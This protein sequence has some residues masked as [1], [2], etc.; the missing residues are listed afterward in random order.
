MTSAEQIGSGSWRHAAFRPLAIPVYRRFWLAGMLSNLG[1]MM[2]SVGAAWLMTSISGKP[3]MVALVQTMT[4]LP[5]MLFSIVAGA[6][7]DIVDRRWLI[8]ASQLGMTVVALVLAGLTLSGCVTP[9][10]LLAATFLIAAGNAI[11]APAWQ[12]SVVEQVSLP[13]LDSAT[14][15]NSVGLNVARAFGPALGGAAVS[16]IGCGP[17]FALNALSNVGLIAASLSWRRER[18]V[19]PLP[20]E[21][22][23]EA[24]FAGFRYAGLSPQLVRLLIR[25]SSFGFCGSCVWAMTPIL[26]RNALGGGPLTLGWLLGGYGVGA[27]AGAVLRAS[28]TVSR[29]AMLALCTACSGV[30]MI[31]LGLSPALWFAIPLM[32]V[33]GG[34]WIMALTGL[35][36][37]VQILVPRWVVGRII[38]MN[39]MAVF[40]GMALGSTLWGFVTSGQ[41]VRMAFVA[42]GIAMLASLLLARWFPLPEDDALDLT[43]TRTELVDPLESPIAAGEGPIVITVEYRVAP[44]NF[45]TFASAMEELG[46]IRRRDGARRWSLQQ[47]MDDPGRWVE[48]FASVSWLG[49]LRRQLRPTRADEAVRSHIAA[50]H[51]GD[52]IV[53]RTVERRGGVRP[54]GATPG[55]DLADY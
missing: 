17:V 7:A 32:T 13:L 2:Q 24:V 1:T 14:S 33:A 18:P 29:S 22:V 8:L 50:L 3:E 20:P 10:S 34:A 12:A 53:R 35:S 49:H 44:A 52:T 15:L 23:L 16:V 54:F 4:T 37:S 21:R 31:G 39:L 25:S 41:G 19:S 46:R 6:L 9:G 5:M 42:A 27:I 30:A 38:S 48:R 47:D 40:A 11:Y 55:Y 28:L 45:A 43:P 51:A 36:V 26:A